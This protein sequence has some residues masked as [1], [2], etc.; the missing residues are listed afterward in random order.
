[1]F[2]SS[3]ELSITCI[4]FDN[5]DLTEACNPLPMSKLTSKLSRLSG[6][7][8]L[9]ISDGSSIILFYFVIPYVRCCVQPVI[10]VRPMTFLC[11]SSPRYISE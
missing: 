9:L 6:I 11:K 5:V 3:F 7:L 4:M 1:M 8:K 2:Y 10:S